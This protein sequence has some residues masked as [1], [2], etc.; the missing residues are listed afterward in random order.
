MRSLLLPGRQVRPSSRT[1]RAV[2]L[3][4]AGRVSQSRETAV[5]HV[6]SGPRQKKN[7]LSVLHCT[8]H[9]GG[10]GRSAACPPVALRGELASLRQARHLLQEVADGGI[11]CTKASSCCDS[12]GLPWLHLKC[13]H[14]RTTRTHTRETW[15]RSSS[16][17]RSL[18]GLIVAA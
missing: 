7:E 13:T 1:N 6:L 14:T 2:L 18:M 17:N 12:N 8:P 9:D 5:D 11:Y 15:K 4:E 16:M 10:D 3:G